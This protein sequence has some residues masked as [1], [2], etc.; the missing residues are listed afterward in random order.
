[1]DEGKLHLE[2]RGID[3]LPW[4]RMGD[5]YVTHEMRLRDILAH[6]SGLGSHAG[7]LL[8]VTPSTYTT[9]EVVERLRDVPLS[10]GFRAT[11]AYENLMYAVAA[12]VIEQASGESYANFVREHIFAPLGMKE[13]HIDASE[14]EPGDDVVTPYAPRPIP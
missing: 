9:R 1:A 8:F 12:L 4:F 13:S 14:L 2:D 3:H 7:D 5:P 10:T 11:F 6:R